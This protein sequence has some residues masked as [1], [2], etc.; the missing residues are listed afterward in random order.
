MDWLA[1]TNIYISYLILLIVFKCYPLGIAKNMQLNFKAANVH[2]CPKK[3]LI[4]TI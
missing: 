1:F 4:R 3:C 2:K